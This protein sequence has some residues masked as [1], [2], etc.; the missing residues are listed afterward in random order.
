ML[1]NIYALQHPI[2]DFQMAPPHYH[3]ALS[4]LYADLTALEAS[5]DIKN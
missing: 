4:P 1:G 3:K 5:R 2:T